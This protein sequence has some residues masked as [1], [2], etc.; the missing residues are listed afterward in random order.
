MPKDILLS[1]T[2]F[3][4]TSRFSLRP[5]S[6]S[7]SNTKSSANRR[8]DILTLFPGT[9]AIFSL[10]LSKIQLMKTLNS[11]GDIGHPCI[12]SL[13][14]LN[15]VDNKVPILTSASDDL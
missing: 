2:H 12:T 14:T 1:F 11:M 10:T 4:T 7:A 8:P 5:T 3:S 15:K 6:E 13:F 9:N